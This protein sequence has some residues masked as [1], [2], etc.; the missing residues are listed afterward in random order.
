MTAFLFVLGWVCL[1]AGTA[2]SQ[3]GGQAIGLVAGLY[4]LFLIW[5]SLAIWYRA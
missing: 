4:G 3:A 1:L 5:R 2:A